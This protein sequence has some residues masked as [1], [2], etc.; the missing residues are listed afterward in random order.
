[1]STLAPDPDVGWTFSGWPGRA[2]RVTVTGGRGPMSV[3]TAELAALRERLLAAAELVAAADEHTVVNPL[4][5]M[6]GVPWA[7]S[8]FEEVRDIRIQGA[9]L[10]RLVRR[11]EDLAAD[12][13]LQRLWYEE[14]ETR[15]STVF[16]PPAWRY[17]VGYA[18]KMLLP[19]RVK[20]AFNATRAAD[21]LRVGG[22]VAATYD[23]LNSS[24][25][26]DAIV[27]QRHAAALGEAMQYM[28][29]D[30]LDGSVKVDGEQVD[31][32][33][34]TPV[35]RSALV[36]LP[37]LT[38]ASTVRH[39]GPPLTDVTSSM[40][41]GP[42][43]AVDPT[44][45][46][47][48]G[49]RGPRGPISPVAPGGSAALAPGLARA[50]ATAVGARVATPLSETDALARIPELE[51]EIGRRGTGAVEILR[52]MTAE[53]RRH[54]TV[55][56]PGTQD[57]WSGGENPMDNET[58]LLAIAGVRSDMAIGVAAAMHQAGIARGEPVALVGHSQGGLVATQ[59]AADP[60]LKHEFRISTVLTAGSPVGTMKIPPGVEVLS[61]E[62]IQDPV[63]GLDG[64]PNAPAPNHI[65]V[66]VGG[67]EEPDSLGDA[68]RLPGYLDAA[69][70]LPGL[71]DPS[72]QQWLDRNR[73]AMGSH[74]EGARTDSMVFEI[75]RR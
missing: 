71:Q 53:G 23:A 74:L 4:E 37:W 51:D 54:W 33:E 6:P 32:R 7:W 18:P 19:A 14:A 1:M 27:A 25:R 36:A 70:L 48:P 58:N 13:E 31:V 57:P 11:I 26:P 35:Q 45:L 72:V 64:A 22:H 17:V 56:I 34:M 66:A 2:T 24:P 29:K 42:T 41:R 50:I 69:D 38:R 49:S 40:L 44:A 30:V 39:A 60:V 8:A 67:G 63:V 46:H 75:R 9:G 28:N 73:E 20:Q 15:A 12:L 3:D 65:T 10:Q 5:Y 43:T 47:V 61:L 16:R 55:V 21:V 59:L 68:H 62:H 52:T